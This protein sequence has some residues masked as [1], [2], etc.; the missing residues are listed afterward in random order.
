MRIFLDAN[1]LFAAALP[2]SRTG[3]FFT[4]FQKH[5]V[6]ITNVYAVEEARRNLAEKKQ[7]SL[8]HFERLLEHIE[9]IDV[10]ITSFNFKLAPK[11]IPILGGAIA[12]NATHLLT[13]D[14]RDFE[15]LWGKT[16]H[17]V[18]IVSPQILTDELIKKGW[19]KKHSHERS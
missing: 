6:L 3:V 9:V 14:K 16:I 11:D 4:E 12:S 8:P 15:P 10:A 17:G 19:L 13:G 7:G 5:A 18:K 1:I 2:K